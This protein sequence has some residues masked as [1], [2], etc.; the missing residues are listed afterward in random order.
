MSWKE[1]MFGISCRVLNT[2]S[3]GEWSMILRGVL[4]VSPGFL[5]GESSL[6]SKKPF[7]PYVR[8]DIYVKSKSVCHI[9]SQ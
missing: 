7:S 4:P 6:C 8:K 2:V 3:V 5:V 1:I 9:V